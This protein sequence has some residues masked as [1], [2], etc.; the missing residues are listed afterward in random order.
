[1]GDIGPNRAQYEVLPADDLA[2]LFAL[3]LA[4]D[5]SAGVPDG[6]LARGSGEGEDPRDEVDR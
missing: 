2:S 3:P 4:N 5:P 6:A 1:M